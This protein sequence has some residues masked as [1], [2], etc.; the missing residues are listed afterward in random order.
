MGKGRRHQ[1]VCSTKWP[2][3]GR[4]MVT[5]TRIPLITISLLVA[6]LGQSFTITKRYPEEWKWLLC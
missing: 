5:P 2:W 3:P 6:L 1:E 4:L